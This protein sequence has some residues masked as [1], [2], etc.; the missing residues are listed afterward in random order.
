ML[1]T[2]RSRAGPAVTPGSSGFQRVAGASVGSSATLRGPVRRSSSGAIDVRQL[3][4]AILRCASV[5]VTCT[6]FSASANV[7]GVTSGPTAGAVP[8]VGGAPATGLP[9]FCVARGLVA[10]ARGGGAEHAEGRGDEKL[11]ARIHGFVRL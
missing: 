2:N 10:L 6:S 8:N 3:A 5:I 4:A 11:A 1:R 9:A 7:A